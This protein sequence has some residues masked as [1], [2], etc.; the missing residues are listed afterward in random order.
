MR[1]PGPFVACLRGAL[2]LAAWCIASCA[3][4]QGPLPRTVADVFQ[5]LERQREPEGATEARALLA[6]PAPTGGDKAALVE[7][8]LARARAAALLGR[9]ADTLRERRR[10]VELTEGERNQPKHLIDL[11]V[12]EMIA[13]HWAEAEALAQR[14]AR[15]PTAW[16]GQ[17]IVAGL[18]LARMQAF[19]GDFANART[20]TGRLD[21]LVRRA[22]L[23]PQ[24]GPFMDLVR[25]WLAWAQADTQLAEGNA[26]AG[27]RALRLAREHGLADTRGAES[28]ERSADYAPASDVT[29][30]V[31]DLVEAQLVRLHIQQGRPQEAELAARQMLSR[32]LGRFGG[33]SPS[34]AASLASLGEVMAAQGRYREAG[35]LGDRAAQVLAA[36]GAGAASGFAFHAERVRIEAR[37]GRQAWTEAAQRVDAAREA[38]KADAYLT[39]ASERQPAW[40]L[41]MLRA[42]RADVAAQWLATLAAEHE[43]SLGAARYETAEARGLLGAA[44]AAKGDRAGAF[45]AFGAALPVLLGQRRGGDTED[46][47]RLA[48]RR[49]ILEGYVGLLHDAQGERGPQAIAEAFR[50]GDA[51]L[52]GAVQAALAASAARAMA[53][54]SALGTLI[55]REQDAK[56]ELVQANDRLLAFALSPAS[57]ARDR[58][59][60][61]LRARIEAMEKERTALFAEIEAKFPDYANLV[62]PQPATLEDA[63]KA[64]RPGEALVMIVPGESRTFV[65]ALHAGGRASFHAAPL[66]AAEVASLVAKLRAALD[67]GELSLARLRAFDVGAAHRLYATLLAPAS[68]T[69]AES[70]DL[71]VATGGALGQLPLALLLTEATSPA[72]A[73]VPFQEM[74]ALPWLARKA[75]VTSVPSVNA[76][77]RL[78]ALPPAGAQRAAFIGFGDPVFSERAAA[79]AAGSGTRLRSL[80]LVR[81]TDAVD[82]TQQQVSHADY[83]TLSPLPDTREEIESIARTLGADPARDAYLG[84]RASRREVRAADLQ[85]RRIVAFATHGLVPGDLPGLSEPALALSATQDPKDSPLLTLEDVLGLRLDADWVVLSACNTAAGDGAGAEAVSGLGRGFFYAGSRAL[86]VTHWP[87]ETVSARLL[88]TGI[89]ERYAGDPALSRAQA[90]NRAM[91]AL[92]DGPGSGRMSYAHP[93][94]WAPYALVGDGAR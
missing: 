29:W 75:S 46:A 37:V 25:S 76:F 83:A 78:R 32:N 84:A 28:R 62:S 88:V 38:V 82:V 81:V 14:A 3:A 30:Q 50:L 45:A 31:L 20:A 60:A 55:R 90:L 26:L 21:G 49:A 8:H 48:K 54:T 44:L 34:V 66:A 64:L 61:E 10:L 80:S 71:V 12:N 92:I 91:L 5:S 86:L 35:A 69:W 9:V 43:R 68:G 24:A 59:M 74:Q 13:G 1:M 65:W 94:F 89:F 67:P 17:D 39:R 18:L 19:L 23:Y 53:G 33:A 73:A 72:P 79:P 47:L 36:A 2:A 85:S 27:E 6:K 57:E 56:R 22:S 87:V 58:A 93:I 63:R 11:C 16:W 52:G 7:Q 70:R 15:A 41:A 51:M 4:A 42:G 77:A 40:A